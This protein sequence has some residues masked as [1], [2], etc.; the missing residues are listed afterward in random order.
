MTLARLLELAAL[1]W[2]EA[3]AVVEGDRRLCYAQLHASSVALGRAFHRLGVGAGDRVLIALRNRLE[4]VVAYWALQTIAAVPTPVNVRL[5][6]AEMRGR[7]VS[8]YFV[9][10]YVGLTL[11]VIGVG[12]AS[13]YVGDVRAVLVCSIVLAVLCAFSMVSMRRARSGQQTSAASKSANGKHV[14]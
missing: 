13:E 9:F 11:P 14:A 2:P 4:H 5:A 6:P 1:R 7:A 3:E 8:T 12:V 10:A